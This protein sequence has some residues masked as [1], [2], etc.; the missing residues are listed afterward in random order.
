MGFPAISFSYFTHTTLLCVCVCT[1]CVR[2]CLHVCVCVCVFLLW[3]SRGKRLWNNW[4]FS[5]RPAELNLKEF[6][7]NNSDKPRTVWT[8][9]GGIVKGAVSELV[10]EPGC[11]TQRCVDSLCFQ[12]QCSVW[13]RLPVRCLSAACSS[14]WDVFHQMCWQLSE[15]RVKSGSITLRAG[16]VNLGL[17]GQVCADPVELGAGWWQTS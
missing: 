11:E 9:F 16:I 17:E 14:L 1:V 12:G 6:I 7:V 3:E 10:T 15:M 2:S 5:P 4:V 13:L 8:W